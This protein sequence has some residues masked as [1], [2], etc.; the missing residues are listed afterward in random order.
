MKKNNSIT[1]YTRYRIVGYS[2]SVE[3]RVAICSA[4][5]SRCAARCGNGVGLY[6]I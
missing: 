6:V 1:L 5:I 4:I 3:H 2:P